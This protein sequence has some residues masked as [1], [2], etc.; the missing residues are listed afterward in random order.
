MDGEEDSLVQTRGSCDDDSLDSFVEHSTDH[1]ED[2]LP[3]MSATIDEAAPVS[4]LD[5]LYHIL[6]KKTLH[7]KDYAHDRGSQVDVAA[8]AGDNKIVS[9]GRG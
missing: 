8:A 2:A 9:N 6:T 5:G 1:P 7:G 3:L 4:Y